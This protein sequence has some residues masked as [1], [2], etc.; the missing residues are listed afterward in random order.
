M[1]P[2]AAI[3]TIFALNGAAFAAWYARLPAI[4]DRLEL[5]PGEIGVALLGAPVGLLLAQGAIG[6]LIARHGSYALLRFCPVACAAVLLPALAVSL[7]TLVLAVTLT[8]AANGAMDVTMNAQ[9]LAVERAAGRR[10]F[11]SLHAGF[12]FGALGGA[13]AAGALAAVGVGPVVHLAAWGLVAAALAALAVRGLLR[14]VGVG[15]EGTAHVRRPRLDAR[16][17]AIGVMAFA[18]LLAE[19]SVTDWSALFLDRVVGAA[20]GTAPLGLAAFSL[21]MG[22]GRLAGDGLAPRIG[23]RA[24]AQG[25]GALAAAGL[26]LALAGATTPTALAGFALMGCGLAS[27]FPLALRAA[28]GEGAAAAPALAAVSAAGYVGFLVGPP[29]IGGLAELVGLRAALLLACGACVVAAALGGVLR[30]GGG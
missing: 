5:G 22:I 1:S 12:S 24:L 11:T 7:P 20:A 17:L 26:G 25:G 8:G 9:G 2:R 27:L 29:A 23:S 30:E 10:L 18:A 14:D 21:T 13:A 16:L 4:A 28:G 3:T 19:G 6:G 15:A